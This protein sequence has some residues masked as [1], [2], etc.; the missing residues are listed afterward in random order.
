[1]RVRVGIDVG[2]TF[3]DLCALSEDGRVEVAKVATSQPDPVDGILQGVREVCR[4][5]DEI[6]SVVLGT[7]AGLNAVL[8]RRGA[9]TALITTAGFGDIYQMARGDR[10]EMYNLHYHRP[11]PLLPRQQIFEVRER[12]GAGGEVVEALDRDQAAEIARTLGERAVESVAVCLLHS[13]SNPNHERSLAEVFERE[14]PGVSLS[15]SHRVSAEWREYERMSTTVVDAYVRPILE[16]HLSKLTEGLAAAGHAPKLFLM[17]SSGGLL[18]AEKA[19]LEPVTVLLSGPVGGVLASRALA[20]QLNLGSILAIDMGG[21]SFDVTLLPEG[22]LP[23][24][25][26]SEIEGFPLQ[27]AS[28]PVHTIGAGGGSV[29]W[30]EGLGL[31]VGPESAGA[32]P[33]PVCYGRGGELPTVTDA[34]ACLGRIGAGTFVGGALSLDV[35]AARQAFEGVAQ[36]VFMS[37]EDLMEGVVEIVNARMV[38]AMR[39]LSIDQGLDVRDFSL[40]A[41]GGNGPLHAAE[42]AEELGVTQVIIPASPGAFSAWGML[43]S[44]VRKDMSLTVVD[45]HNEPIT[46]LAGPR[47]E[48]LAQARSFLARSGI[49][50]A[51]TTYHWRVDMRYPGQEHSVDVPLHSP[52]AE[53][54]LRE[55]VTLFH[56][57][58]HRRYGHSHPGQPVE[59][60]TLR[61]GVHGRAQAPEVAPIPTQLEVGPDTDQFRSVRWQGEQKRVSVLVRQQLKPGQR[62]HGPAIIEEVT[63]TT[64]VPVDWDFTV[65]E[66]TGSLVL[67]RSKV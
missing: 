50:E 35:E 18:P 53:S 1:M 32:Q 21:T 17:R 31:R 26:Q 46:S 36:K 42:L 3:T 60:V 24:T 22:E 44:E 14:L 34:N 57:L 4:R 10:V 58:H 19:L 40:V 11:S 23:V 64:F 45:G 28:V 38:S 6:I 15:L 66:R 43:F 5:G 62:G 49:S 47:R 59:M 48:L 12:I 16:R 65:D 67:E 63:A 7:T 2:G 20:K 29:V 27:I 61:L 54:Y 55:A 13:F 8:E 39:V 37:L 51:E 33:G 30:L 9:K 41:Y 25:D 52:S 56:E